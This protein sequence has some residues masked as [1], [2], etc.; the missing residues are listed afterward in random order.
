MSHFSVLVIGEDAEGQLARFDENM[1]VEAHPEPYERGDIERMLDY[2]RGKGSEEI[3]LAEHPAHRAKINDRGVVEG[4]TH[5]ELLTMFDTWTGGELRLAGELDG[6]HAYDRW[7][8]YNP[9]SKWDW[10]QIGGRWTGNF[11]LKAGGEGEIGEPGIMTEAAK[12][13][14]ADQVLKRDIDIQGMRD[15]AGYVADKRWREVHEVLD[16]FPAFDSWAKVKER[17]ADNIDAARVAYH[18]QPAVEAVK[19][20]LGFFENAERYSV[21]LAEFVQTARDSAL[22]S[23]AF[24][25]DGEWYQKGE[26]GWFGM[27]H[28]EQSDDEWNQQFNKMLDELPGNTMLT[29]VDCHI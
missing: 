4:I 29:C 6:G 2:Y 11:K 10:Y 9:D 28:N 16:K 13:G 1:E 25:R 23:Y 21:A 24:V 15:A 3:T 14:F 27:S 8:T 12:E 7:T 18:G 22:S 26:M 20:L 17:H 19:G 5:D